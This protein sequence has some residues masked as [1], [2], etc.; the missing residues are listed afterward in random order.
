MQTYVMMTR[1][2]HGKLDVPKTLEHLENEVKDRIKESLG[3]DGFEWVASYALGGPYDYMDIFR[4]EDNDAAIKVSTIVR[5]FGHAQ[6]EVWP[7]TDWGHFKEMARSLP[8]G[9]A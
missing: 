1:L 6:S 9:H 8:S 7:A 4:A 2:D 3:N 5:T